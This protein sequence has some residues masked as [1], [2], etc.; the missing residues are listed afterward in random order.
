MVS[1]RYTMDQFNDLMQRSGISDSLSKLYKD[2]VR[3]P[4]HLPPPPAH[5][6]PLPFELE[7]PLIPSMLLSSHP[8]AA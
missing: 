4:S 6:C 1:V 2:T 8:P 7:D 3:A 5:P